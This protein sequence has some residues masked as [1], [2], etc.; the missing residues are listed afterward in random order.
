MPAR[1]KPQAPTNSGKFLFYIIEAIA[2]QTIIIVTILLIFMHKTSPKLRFQSLSVQ[3]LTVN[4]TS[5]PSF[6][7]R[8]NGEV[9]LKNSNFGKF[10]F[11]DGKILILYRD[12]A[13]GDAF[14][15]AGRVKA[16]STEKMNVTVVVESK[17]DRDL[18]GD[19]NSGKITLSSNAKWHGKIRVIR[20]KTTATMN[21]TMDVDTRTRAVQN[22][23]C[24]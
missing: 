23:K 13:V 1:T 14:V 18:G 16:W 10:N 2:F 6:F 12:N 22:L 17:N 21:C 5:P 20:R 9:T 4:A 8:L 7:F 11:P 19:L 3:N 15:P 24:S